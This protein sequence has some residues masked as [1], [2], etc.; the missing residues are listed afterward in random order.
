MMFHKTV[1]FVGNRDRLYRYVQQENGKIWK[2]QRF[3]LVL[4]SNKVKRYT[5][6]PFRFYCKYQKCDNGYNIQYLPIPTG[7]HL[8]CF[9][10]TIVFL[11][12]YCYHRQ[13]N[14]F[15]ACGLFVLLCFPNYCIQR[16]QCI[17]Q[18]EAVCQK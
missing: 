2:D 16:S 11:G 3:R 18:F 13:W 6:I 8:L 9:L 4:R 17:R 14:P 12:L 15:I 1:F 5:A 10:L 7:L